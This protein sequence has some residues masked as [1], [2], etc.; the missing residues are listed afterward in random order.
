METLQVN[1]KERD[2]LAMFSRVR[3]KQ[4]TLIEASRRLDL[5]YRQAK[6]L[7]R[8]YRAEGDGGAPWRTRRKTRG[9]NKL[10]FVRH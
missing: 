5:S 7:W 2:R 4:V 8:R 6:R 3:D 9:R 10:S 1:L